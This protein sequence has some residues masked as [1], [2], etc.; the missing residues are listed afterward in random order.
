MQELA[1]KNAERY[2]KVYNIKLDK[3]FAFYK[4]IEEI[5]EFSQSRLIS[6]KKS[7]SEKFK[8]QSEEELKNLQAKELADILGMVFVNAKILNIDLEKSINEKWFKWL[9]KK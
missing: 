9:E 7:R 6:E 3:D 5:G 8:N 4:L 2:C 1:F